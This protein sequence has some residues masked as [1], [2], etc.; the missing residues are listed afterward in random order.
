MA[1]PFGAKNK[2]PYPETRHYNFYWH[3]VADRWQGELSAFKRMHDRVRD[4]KVPSIQWPRTL[5]GFVEFIKAAG[6]I[7]THLHKPSI[8]RIKHHIGYRRCNVRWEEH[9]HNS[10]KRRGTK[11]ELFEGA[12][13][14]FKILKFKKGTPEHLT[15]QSAASKAR[16]NKPGQREQARIRMLGNHHQI[17][18]KKEAL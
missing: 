14:Q 8:G 2:Q 11:W 15:H 13:V 18:K 4:G 6:P 7:P 12:E 9:R 17:G 3:I 16:W 10:V 5:D 1:K